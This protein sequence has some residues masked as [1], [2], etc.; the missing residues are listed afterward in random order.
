MRSSSVVVLALAA[1]AAA[2]PIKVDVEARQGAAGFSKILGNVASGAGILS[3]G[4]N[5]G[6]FLSGLFGGDEAAAK[7]ALVEIE[8]LVTRDLVSREVPELEARQGAAGFSKILGNLASGA[9]I[10][11]GGINIGNFLGGLLGGDDAAAR[12]EIMEIGARE[13]EA[14]QGA[15]G[16][17][18]ILGNV[19]SGA[20]LLS[21]G[22][23]IGNFLGGLFGGDEA[24]AKRS[25]VEMEEH[26]TRELIAREVP[27]L[28]ARQGAAGFSKILGNLASGAGLLSGGI[29]I[30]NFLGGLFGGDEAAAKRDLAQIEDHMARE[31]IAR[32]VPELEGSPRSCRLLQDSRKPRLRCWYPL[33]RY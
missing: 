33:F 13:L 12:R 20:G 5:I 28:E 14:R 4:I 30:G 26:L 22:I 29:N 1:A 16:F 32:E 8:D 11:S 19:A 18:K 21:S 31:L 2:A 3:S 10:L 17:S 15:A 23:N 24:A 7:R 9:G 27:E 6:N 25:L